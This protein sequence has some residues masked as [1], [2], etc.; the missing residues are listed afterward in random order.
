MSKTLPVV[1]ELGALA[2][3]AEMEGRGGVAELDRAANV[4]EALY[5]ALKGTERTLTA[6]SYTNILG[7]TQRERLGAARA[8]LSLAEK[9]P[10]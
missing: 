4:I 6:F 9:E 2:T 8:A 10:E 3:D 5:V 1:E 7:S